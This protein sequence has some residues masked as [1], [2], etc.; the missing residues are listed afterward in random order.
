MLHKLI[1]L[2]K[3]PAFALFI[4]EVGLHIHVQHVTEVTMNI[5]AEASK[6]Q[7]SCCMCTVEGITS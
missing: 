1:E 4:S 6:V 5:L 3:S 7:N 2:S